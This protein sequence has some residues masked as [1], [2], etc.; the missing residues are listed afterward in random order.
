MKGWIDLVD[1]AILTDITSEDETYST[2]PSD[3][4]LHFCK[5]T[6]KGKRGVVTMSREDI[7]TGKGL[8]DLLLRS[9]F[10]E[11]KMGLVQHLQAHSKWRQ[12]Y[13]ETI[14]HEEIIKEWQDLVVSKG[15]K[16][17]EWKQK[18]FAPTMFGSTPRFAASS[19]EPA[20]K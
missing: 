4:L 13:V 20:L 1:Y 2:D 16:K 17:E 6:S 10:I 3:I 5:P 11:K 8:K 14:S 19:V 9:I 15:G 7:L 12:K 18:V